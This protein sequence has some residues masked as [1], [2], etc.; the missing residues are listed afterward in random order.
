[1]VLGLDGGSLSL[2]PLYYYKSFL[3]ELGFSY[4]LDESMLFLIMIGWLLN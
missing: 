4:V 1:M 3:A 2:F